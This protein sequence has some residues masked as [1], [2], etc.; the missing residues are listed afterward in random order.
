MN[1][2]F[3]NVK[4]HVEAQNF[5]FSI[6]MDEF[7]VWELETDDPMDQVLKEP[8]I[9]KSFEFTINAQQPQVCVV[10]SVTET[11]EFP[12]LVRAGYNGMDCMI[13]NFTTVE[14]S[15]CGRFWFIAKEFQMDTV[16]QKI[17][18]IVKDPV[19]AHNILGVV[20]NISY[21]PSTEVYLR[22]LV[23]E[24]KITKTMKDQLHRYFLGM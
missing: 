10:I 9:G 21:P 5:R 22:Q 16:I 17:I 6:S 15:D 4:V 24:N 11:Q 12:L 14:G 18:R 2:K 19:I 7:T 3:V 23:K 8:K 20:N 1:Q 13:H